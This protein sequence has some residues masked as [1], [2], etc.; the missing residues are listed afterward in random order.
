M[1]LTD[2]IVMDYQCLELVELD[3][4][5]GEVRLFEHELGLALDSLGVTFC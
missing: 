2:M 1:N 3:A 4:K 5:L